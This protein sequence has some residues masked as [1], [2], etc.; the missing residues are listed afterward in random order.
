MKWL[1]ALLWLQLIH[2]TCCI[3]H[4]T[5][6]EN[7]PRV[8]AFYYLW[9][10]SPEHD[11]GWKHWD[12]EVLPHWEDRINEKFKETIGTRHDPP[13]RLY[14]PFELNLNIRLKP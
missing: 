8:H 5:E 13:G 11:G 14:S 12:H 10:G 3:V 6:E 4:F 1:I 9:Y 2:L 7:T